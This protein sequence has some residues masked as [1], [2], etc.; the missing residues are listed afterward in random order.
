MT[1]LQLEVDDTLIQFLGIEVLQKRLEAFIHWESLRLQANQIEQ[2][3]KGS[4][5]DQDILWEQ[6]RQEA[7]EDYQKHNP[8]PS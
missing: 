1:T 6:A 8:L 3:A 4:G 5:L 7:W 2:A